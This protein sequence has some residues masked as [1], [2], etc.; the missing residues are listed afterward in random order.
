M[1]RFT[2]PR[3]SGAQEEDCPAQRAKPADGA[4]FSSRTIASRQ[5]LTPMPPRR[6]KRGVTGGPVR[7]LHPPPSSRHGTRPTLCD[8]SFSLALWRP[9]TSAGY[10]TFCTL[11]QLMTTVR[12]T[13]ARGLSRHAPSRGR[14]PGQRPASRW[15]RGAALRYRGCGLYWETCGDPLRPGMSHERWRSQRV[16]ASPLFIRTPPVWA[17][18][19]RT[20]CNGIPRDRD[21]ELS[22]SPARHRL[23]NSS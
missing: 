6:R 5:S 15:R 12:Y 20:C 9:T 19:R 21:I 11:T 17:R 14:Q 8:Q 13:P 7:V 3:W 1:A 10:D 2:S 4:A 18:N 22:D 23:H 16:S